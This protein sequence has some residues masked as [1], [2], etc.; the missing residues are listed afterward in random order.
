MAVYM[1]LEKYDGSTTRIKISPEE[2]RDAW[3]EMHCEYCGKKIIELDE[4]SFCKE[5]LEG[6]IDCMIW[7]CSKEC[8]RAMKRRKI[9]YKFI[10]D[11]FIPMSEDKS[12]EKNLQYYMDVFDSFEKLFIATCQVM[13][14][15]ERDPETGRMWKDFLPKV[16]DIFYEKFNSRAIDYLKDYVY[17][18]KD[19]WYGKKPREKSEADYKE[20]IVENFDKIFTNYDLVQS[21]KDISIGR[22]D[23]LAKDRASNRDVII[24]LK[25]G[26]KN[27]TLQLL[28]YG[29]K[30]IDP[31]LIG[32]TEKPLN[33]ESKVDGI[34]Y[35][36]YEE[37]IS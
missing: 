20:R 18:Q 13:H 25:V 24:E 36:T 16:L 21:E 15:P 23:I 12:G 4:Y 37:L 28:A 34:L 14:G 10:P 8:Y 29:C 31:I 5:T 27:P 2:I 22:V 32:I 35:Y 3:F 7:Y 30:F 1:N 26:N 6:G 11:R 17:F 33:K 19:W 9:I